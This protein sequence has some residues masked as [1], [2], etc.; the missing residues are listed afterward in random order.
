MQLFCGATAGEGFYHSASPAYGSGSASRV[1]RAGAGSVRIGSRSGFKCCV[2]IA[3]FGSV[4]V[5]VGAAASAVATLAAPA[6]ADTLETAL[7]QAYRTT[8]RSIRSAPRC[9][10]PTK[11]CRGALSG[12][13]PRVSVNAT[14]RRA[15]SVERPQRPAAS[16]RERRPIISRR[17]ATT[18]RTAPASTVTQT[19]FNGFQTANRTRQAES[20]VSPRARRCAPPSRPCCST[21][22]PPT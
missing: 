20:Q 6:R 21:P 8:R 18:R 3:A 1:G 16:C 11:T 7:V 15:V 19:L 5:A 22:P 14:G 12:Y 4:R 2:G 9:A 10:R 17:A 13:R